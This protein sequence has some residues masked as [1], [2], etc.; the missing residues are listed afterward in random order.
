MDMGLSSCFDFNAT[1]AARAAYVDIFLKSTPRGGWTPATDA[2]G[3]R[4]P[5]FSAVCFY[6]ALHLKA[7]VPALAGVPIGLVQSSVG[8]TAIETWM[9]ADALLAAGVPAAEAVCGVKGCSN[10]S[11]CG[12]FAPLIAPLAPTVFKAMLWY[13]GESDVACNVEPG[14]HANSYARLLP[15]LVESWRALFATPFTALVVMLAPSARTDEVPAERSADAWPVLRNAQLSVLALNGTGMIYPID[16]GDD[17]KTVYTPPTPRHGGLH[18]RNKTEF[19]RRLALA[20]AEAEGLLPAGVVARGPDFAG[21]AVEAG[22]ATVLVTFA[23]GPARA[24]L[25][26]APTTDCATDGRVPPPGNS[27]A[28]CCQN[29]VTDARSPHGFPFE[30][31]A[32]GA[33]V[34]ARA[35]VVAAPDGAPAVRLAPLAATGAAL[36]GRVRYAWDNW[37]LCGVVNAAGLPLPPFVSA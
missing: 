4:L 32:G 29:D 2:S 6:T 28:H 25:A 19:G 7:L 37:P 23:P 31:E 14:W 17:G 20:W 24:A 34:L 22:G 13:Q 11:Y 26:L 1:M 35:A 36:S 16:M 3:T 27:S 9:S 5:P 18:P 12:N 30:L 33:W 8:G 15:S 10:Q 21:A